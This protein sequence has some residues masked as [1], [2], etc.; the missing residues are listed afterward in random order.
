M[1]TP[2]WRQLEKFCRVEGWDDADA[3]RGRPTGD[4]RRFRL[5]LPSGDVLRTKVSH[6]T[7][8][9]GRDLFKH[10]LGE[11]LRVTEK[12]FW[13]AVD[14][15]IPPVRGATPQPPAGHRLPAALV[16][17]LVRDYGVTD[18][19]LRTMSEEQARRR[20]RE[21]RRKPATS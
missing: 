20:L 6:G 13:R 14:K 9:I 19:E 8:Q 15:G 5:T 21:E 1:R 7:G 16:E 2:T 12:D 4:H 18:A 11:Q 17:P 10:I 3:L